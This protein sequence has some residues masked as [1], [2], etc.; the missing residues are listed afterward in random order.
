MC[1]WLLVSIIELGNQA[2]MRIMLASLA[3]SQVGFFQLLSRFHPS[4]GQKDLERFGEK[5]RTCYAKFSTQFLLKGDFLSA[6]LVSG[7]SM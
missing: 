5:Y 4:S 2:V 7:L 1:L 3:G 6:A